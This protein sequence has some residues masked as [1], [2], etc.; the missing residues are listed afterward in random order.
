MLK[1]NDPRLFDEAWKR[2]LL[3]VFRETLPFEEVPIRVYYRKRQRDEEFE[4][5]AETEVVE[6]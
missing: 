4:E 2:Y 1:C 6:N 3:G 5:T